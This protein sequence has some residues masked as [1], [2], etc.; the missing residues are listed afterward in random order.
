[1]NRFSV[2]LA[3]FLASFSS[4]ADPQQYPF[5]LAM[6]AQSD[7]QVV[8]AQNAG[9]APILATVT[10]RSPVNAVVDH[11]SPIV[12]V[13]NPNESVPVA[14]VRRAETGKGYRIS[15]SYK[16]SLGDP[17]AK[18]DSAATYQL[19]FKAGQMIKIGQVV[20][21]RISTHTGPDSHYAIDFSIPVGTPVLAARKGRVVDVDKDFTKGGNDPALKAN[22]VLILHEDGTLGMYSHF[23]ANRIAVTSGEVVEAGTLLGYSGNTGYST[24]PHLHFAVLINTR[25]PDGSAKYASVPVDFVRGSPGEKIQF[26]QDET[27]VVH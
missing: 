27:L 17:D 16:F 24:G 14:T 18:H 12:V 15:T 5:K 26:H 9:P 6:R 1:M 3:L 2:S 8:F 23:A 22:H 4:F 11:P 20:D 25:T 21:G 7:G 19:P 10:L 13:V